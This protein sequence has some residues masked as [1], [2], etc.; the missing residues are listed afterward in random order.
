MINNFNISNNPDEL[1]GIS[2]LTF[3]M[4]AN[5]VLSSLYDDEFFS[6]QLVKSFQNKESKCKSIINKNGVNIFCKIIVSKEAD[7]KSL[8]DFLKKKISE[9]IKNYTDISAIN[10]DVEIISVK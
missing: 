5:N 10:V 2:V 6:K 8:T 4:I 7:I 9:E 3:S 1:L